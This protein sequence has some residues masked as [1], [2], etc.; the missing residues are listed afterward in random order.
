[1]RRL[2]GVRWCVLPVKCSDKGNSRQLVT[3][4]VICSDKGNSRQVVT[5]PVIYSKGH[6]ISGPEDPEVE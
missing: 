5:L 4:P 2:V 3:L 1:V 6:S